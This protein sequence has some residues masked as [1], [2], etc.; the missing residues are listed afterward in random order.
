VTI[1]AT[2]TGRDEPDQQ[3]EGDV[4]IEASVFEG[5]EPDQQAEWT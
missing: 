5:D 4:T 1:E 2:T 3:V